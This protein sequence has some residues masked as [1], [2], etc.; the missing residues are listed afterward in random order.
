MTKKVYKIKGMDCASCA[1]LLEMDLEDVG[2][3]GKCSY[4]K[5]TLEVEQKHDF[6][7][8]RKIIEKSGFSII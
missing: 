3:K 7:T 8:I 6:D 1:S 2:I 4:P 5:E